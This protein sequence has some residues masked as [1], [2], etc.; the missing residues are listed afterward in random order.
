MKQFNVVMTP[1]FDRDLKSVM[2]SRRLPNKSA[3][4]RAAVHE[5]AARDALR[6]EFSFR[7]LLGAGLKA[8]LSRKKRYLTEDDLWS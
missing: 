4:L 2:K 7:Q 8:P 6:S 1:E 5:M 3:A